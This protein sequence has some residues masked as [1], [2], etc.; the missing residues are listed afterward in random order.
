[1]LLIG[2]DVPALGPTTGRGHKCMSEVMKAES[3]V[4]NR[5]KGMGTLSPKLNRRGIPTGVDIVT[6]KG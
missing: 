1:M 6:V 3:S 2:L 4:T 5:R